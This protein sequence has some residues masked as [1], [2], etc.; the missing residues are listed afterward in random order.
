MKFMEIQQKVKRKLGYFILEE[1]APEKSSTWVI[2]GLRPVF[3]KSSPQ[4]NNPFM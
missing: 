3:Q 4:P 2:I 1:G